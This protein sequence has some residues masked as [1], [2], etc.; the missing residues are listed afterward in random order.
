[1][2]SPYSNILL[3]RGEMIEIKRPTIT[4]DTWGNSVLTLNE[5]LTVQ[6]VARKTSSGSNPQYRDAKENVSTMMRFY[7]EFHD[8]QKDDVVIYGGEQYRI[9]SVNNVMH[10]GRIMQVDGYKG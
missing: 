5:H 3:N 9:T 6:G 2:T 4:K 8:I 1:M 7:F 10:Y